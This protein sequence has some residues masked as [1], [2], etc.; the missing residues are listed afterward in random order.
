MAVNSTMIYWS[1]LP[2]KIER[3]F[4]VSKSKDFVEKSV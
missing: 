2:R 4:K 1:S 3:N